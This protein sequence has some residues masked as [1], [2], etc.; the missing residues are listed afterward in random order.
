[1][2]RCTIQKKVSALMVLSG[3]SA[4][5]DKVL[6]HFWHQLEQVPWIAMWANPDHPITALLNEI[7]A[8]LMTGGLLYFFIRRARGSVAQLR[9]GPLDLWMLIGLVLILLTGWITT[10]VRLNSSHVQQPGYFS[11]IACPLA[12]LFKGL[13]IPWDTFFDVLYVVHGLLTSAVIV[14]IPFSKFMHVIAGALV[15]IINQVNEDVA[16]LGCEKGDAHGRA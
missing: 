16:R 10:V 4:I 15:A 1:M 8:V 12:Q 14:Y 6:I 11:F 5:A 3:L 7:G 9:T 2:G 13:S